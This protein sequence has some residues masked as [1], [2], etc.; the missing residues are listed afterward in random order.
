MFI[1]WEISTLSTKEKQSKPNISRL[2][3]INDHSMLLR[4]FNLV[5][6]SSHAPPIIPCLGFFSN[7]LSPR[8]TYVINPDT[9]IA[10]YNYFLDWW[11]LQLIKEHRYYQL[12]VWD[13]FQVFNLLQVLKLVLWVDNYRDNKFRKTT[14]LVQDISPN[15]PMIYL[16][17]LKGGSLEFEINV[18]LLK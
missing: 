1:F 15:M 10:T 14:R 17:V 16:P 5:P 8:F 3:H 7:C 11:A 9:C 13:Q 6:C 18:T 2:T 4:T 12:H